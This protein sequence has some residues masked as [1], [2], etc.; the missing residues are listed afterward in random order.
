MSFEIFHFRDSDKILEDKH[1]TQDV[2]DTMMYIDDAL[3]GTHYK[4]EIFRQVLDEMGW[5]GENGNRR[6]LDGR[7]YLY[8]GFKKGIALEGNFA[9]YEFILE[10]LFR[11]QVGFDKKNIDTGILILN[12]HRSE[13]SPYGT[14][15]DMVKVEIEMLFPSVSLPVSIAL[16][17]LEE[18]EGKE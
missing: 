4:R 5:I 2:L 16:F 17:N 9:A 15:A 3:Y 13:K 10:G 8:K 18:Q 7:R 14:S 11:L 12:A 1:M 6:I